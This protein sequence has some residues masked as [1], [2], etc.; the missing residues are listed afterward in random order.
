MLN[1]STQFHSCNAN[2][3]LGTSTHETGTS[4]FALTGNP[5]TDLA[6]YGIDLQGCTIRYLREP[7]QIGN[8]ITGRFNISGREETAGASTYEEL[9][10]FLVNKVQEHRKHVAESHAC[11]RMRNMLTFINRYPDAMV[12]PSYFS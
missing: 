8:I 11:K 7:N 1:K 3:S 9:I 10:L 12:L 6:I 5:Y 4:V 2:D